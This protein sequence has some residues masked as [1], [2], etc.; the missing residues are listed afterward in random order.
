MNEMFSAII[1]LV[2]NGGQAAVWI[3]VLHYVVSLTKFTLGMGLIFYAI[4]AIVKGIVA[5][6]KH[7][8]DVHK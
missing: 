2:K 4:R 6:V 7:D 3:A 8:I 5:L 1:E